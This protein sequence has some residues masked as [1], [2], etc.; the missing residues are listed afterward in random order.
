MESPSSQPIGKGEGSRFYSPLVR[1][2]AQQENITLTE[3]ENIAGYIQMPIACRRVQNHFTIN[4]LDLLIGRQFV[5]KPIASL[6]LGLQFCLQ[7][8]NRLGKLW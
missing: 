2:I 5:I 8:R 1:N 7:Y 6:T 3:L 4:E